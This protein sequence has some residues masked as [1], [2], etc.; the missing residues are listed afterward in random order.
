MWD[1]EKEEL[2]FMMATLYFRFNIRALSYHVKLTY[3]LMVF[4]K[5]KWKEERFP[6]KGLH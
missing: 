5:R 6:E 2:D 3:V 1:G 4:K